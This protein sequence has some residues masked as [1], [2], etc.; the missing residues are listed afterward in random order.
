MEVIIRCLEALKKSSAYN[1]VEDQQH[2]LDTAL[3][4]NGINL[5]GGQKQRIAIA[6]EL[7]KDIDILIMDEATSALDSETEKMIQ[8]NIDAP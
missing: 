7:Y 1:F 6:R 3:G 8:E 2:G 5:T 4:N